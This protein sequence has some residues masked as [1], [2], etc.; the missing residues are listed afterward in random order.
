[1]FT[2]LL[3][4]SLATIRVIQDFFSGGGS[5]FESIQV[6]QLISKFQER[7]NS[8]SFM[9]MIYNFQTGSERSLSKSES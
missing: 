1:M 4:L 8:D 3:R 6:G 7:G 2:S 9:H 5:N